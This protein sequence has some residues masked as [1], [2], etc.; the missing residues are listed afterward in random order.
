VHISL[1]F[2]FF[3]ID[4]DAN[5]NIGTVKLPKPVYVAGDAGGGAADGQATWHGGGTTLWL[6][7][8]ARSNAHSGYPGSG[9]SSGGGQW[10]VD[11]GG[12][13]AAHE[14][15]HI[16]AF[17]HQQV[18]KNVGAI[19]ADGG[20][21]DSFI[22]VKGV[23]SHTTILLDDGNAS[24][25]Y[26]GRG[27]ADLTGGSGTD[28]IEAGPGAAGPITFTGGSG[29][30]YMVNHSTAD[31]VAMTGG[32]GSATII[33]GTG[34][35]GILTGGSGKTVITDNG[36]NDQIYGG[37]G[38]VAVTIHMPSAANQPSFRGLSG[39][40]N[41]LSIT[42]T[43]NGDEML[44]SKSTTLTSGVEIDHIVR[45]AQNNIVNLG[46]VGATN[47]TE[48][49]LNSGAGANTI[50]VADLSGSTVQQLSLDAGQNVVDT[51]QTQLVS[52]PNNP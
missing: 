41:V 44:I 35:N 1:S 39:P 26:D 49:L 29:T 27:G 28:Y 14:N 12:A 4:A 2:L 33:G 31:N 22:V 43:P 23:T 21:A 51:G 3:S 46:A 18:F 17:G 36:V 20:T 15:V 37:S 30:M 40:R 19:V 8:G 6:N 45:N 24:V 38:D 47:V 5:F 42:G 13:T 52:D 11:D 16:T 48:L 9:V 50:T 34:R 10:T 25:V 32:S 7:T